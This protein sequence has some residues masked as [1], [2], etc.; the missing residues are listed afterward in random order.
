[1]SIF[2][3]VCEALA[4][5]NFQFDKFNYSKKVIKDGQKKKVKK[6][7]TDIQQEYPNI[8]ISKVIEETGVD[9]DYSIGGAKNN[10]IQ[11]AQGKGNTPITEEEK[12]KLIQL[13]VINLESK[14]QQAKQQRDEAKSKNNQAKEL[15]QQVSEQ[16]KKRGQTHEEQ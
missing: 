1:M 3:R 16:L 14:L 7:L 2:V 12:Q 13:G 10:A 5:Q 15:E 6:T 8:D 9:I 11:A 4:R